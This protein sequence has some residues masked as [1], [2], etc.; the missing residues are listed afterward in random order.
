MGR[1]ALISHAA[2]K[3]HV[4]AQKIRQQTLPI[5]KLL[6]QST[7][8]GE[9]ISSLPIQLSS[10]SETVEEKSAKGVPSI[11]EQASN[12]S[13]RN[14]SKNQGSEAIMKKFLI[15]EHVTEAEI[16]I[17]LYSVIHHSSLRS[18]GD[19]VTLF[20]IIFPDSEIS[21]G[22][23][24]QKDKVKYTVVYGLAPYFKKKLESKI[25]QCLHVVVGFDECLNKIAQRQQMDLSIRFW[26]DEKNKVIT[27]Y[28]DSVF[29]GHTRAKDLLQGLKAAVQESNISKI[30]QIGMDGPNVN[31]KMINDLD[32]ELKEFSSDNPLPL[33]T[34]SCGLH[35]THGAL[36][37]GIKASNWK[38]L[39]LF[40]ALYNFFKDCPARRQD[41]SK[42]T[43]SFDF[44]LKFCDVRWV[45]NGKVCD[46][47]LKMLV[48]LR[49]YINFIEDI[50]KEQEKKQQKNDRRKR[51]G[52]EDSKKKDTKQYGSS[53]F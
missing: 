52:K 19:L 29:L 37:A 20:S 31:F 2:G 23:K 6:S 17:C 30:I 10:P 7:V 44:P 14:T 27:K 32:L 45:E 1:T 22:M 28:F 43:E 53:H 38:L 46:R 15:K 49:K 35:S 3:K 47:V 40:R 34:G 33:K 26:C 25:N 36:K 12:E 11:L 21:K 4:Q 51:R 16:M 42:I 5:S 8:A 41:Y 9:N 50:K 13:F 18:I 24:L 48:P 39:E